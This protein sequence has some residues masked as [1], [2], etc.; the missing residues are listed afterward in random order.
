[1]NRTLLVGL[2]TLA[3]LAACGGGGGSSSTPSAATPTPVAT[4]TATPTAT[5]APT[6]T[7]TPTATPTTS[8]TPVPATPEGLWI[9]ST[10]DSRTVHGFVLDDNSFW[11]LYSAPNNSAVVAGGIQGSYS[12]TATAFTSSSAKDFSLEGYGIINSSVGATYSAKQNFNGQISYTSTSRTFTSQYNA[13]YENTPALAG[14]AGTYT[15]KS[16]ASATEVI[17]LTLSAAGAISGSGTSGCT[18]FGT[19]TPRSKGNFY[20]VSVT[21]NG[22]VCV[23]GTNTVTGVLYHDAAGNRTYSMALNNAKTNGFIFIGAKQ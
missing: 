23:N 19:A 11:V 8:P 16:S 18:F 17:T 9:G 12:A 3:L 13:A 2:S 7:A 6:A 22:G 1:M 20:I 14:I 15:G 21:F 4:P 5:A 10:S